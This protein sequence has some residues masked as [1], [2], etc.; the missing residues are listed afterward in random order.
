LAKEEE[1]RRTAP[2]TSNGNPKYRIKLLRSLVFKLVGFCIRSDRVDSFGEAAS[3]RL[4]RRAGMRAT[5]EY[6]KVQSCST[7]VE[8]AK[9]MTCG[10]RA[11]RE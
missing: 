2:N 8:A 9:N 4:V 10:R 7:G 6:W 11:G 1:H 3:L 5:R